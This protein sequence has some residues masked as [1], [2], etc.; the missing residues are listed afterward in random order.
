VIG[1]SNP[2]LSVGP[3]LALQGV[4]EALAGSAAPV[5]AV[6]PVIAGEAVKGPTARMMAA[7]EGEASVVAVGRLYAPV[8]DGLLVDAADAGHEPALMASGLAVGVDNILMA[9]ETGRAKVA[10]GA[11]ALAGAV[12]GGRRP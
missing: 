12:L 1:P 10:S 2:Y 11:L 9:D 3:I 7:M 5:V 4:V 6:S 8:L